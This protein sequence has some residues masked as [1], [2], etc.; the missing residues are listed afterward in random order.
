[1]E[2]EIAFDRRRASAHLRALPMSI[3][4]IFIATIPVYLTMGLG[5]LARKTGVLMAG[6][7][8]GVMRLA[9]TI[10]YPCFIIERI[11]GNPQ[12]MDGRQVLIAASLGFVLIALGIAVSYFV[13]PWIGLRVGEGR[14]TFS[15]T[16][17][18]QN[19]GYVAIPIIE[20]LFPG[21][22]TVGVM[23][24]F[25]LGVEIALWTIAV[26][27]LTGVGR[28]P[29]KLLINPPVIAILG[30]LLAN[31][32][33]IN[34]LLPNP[35]YVSDPAQVHAV[36]KVFHT[37]LAQIGT[38]AI[39]LSVLLIGATIYDLWSGERIQWP[40][41]LASPVLRLVLLPV[42]FFAAACLLPL[43]VE[44]KRILIVQGAM[45]SAVFTIVLARHYGGHALTAV[46]V[47]LAT[48]LVSLFT[49]PFAISLGLRLAGIEVA[50]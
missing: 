38:C 18:M 12:L 20:S 50:R 23:F 29:W 40:V 3:A 2:N 8:Q 48:T 17:G 5:A 9:V 15:I 42:A 30:A 45:P 27:V 37:V 49:M 32:L 35:A 6:V 44:L 33:G 10:L 21:K 36:A 19:Y 4:T 7:D 39:P 47:V 13:A 11:L 43:S 46:Q 14:R 31:Y 41:A 34:T 25:T 22:E 28:A 24:T 16:C 1:V 26:G